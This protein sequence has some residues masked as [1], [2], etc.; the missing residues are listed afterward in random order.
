M[1]FAFQ[2]FAP[3]TGAAAARPGKLALQR[4]TLGDIFEDE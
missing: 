2:H 1:T 3:L 4:A